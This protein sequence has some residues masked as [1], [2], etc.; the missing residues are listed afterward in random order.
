[1]SNNAA[2]LVA[3]LPPAVIVLLHNERYKGGPLLSIGDINN[4]KSLDIK[5]N[6]VGGISSCFQCHQTKHSKHIGPTRPA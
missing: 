4:I 2:M 6:K 1:V 3:D 5:K